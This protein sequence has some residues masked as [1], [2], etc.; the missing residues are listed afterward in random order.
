MREEQVHLYKFHPK[1]LAAMKEANVLQDYLPKAS[2]ENEKNFWL[3]VEDAKKPVNRFITKLIRVKKGKQEYFFYHEEVKSKNIVGTPIH[4][5]HTVGKV[6]VPQYIQE[7]DEKTR[8]LKTTDVEGYQTE[9]ELSWPK[10]FTDELK[11]MVTENCDLTLINTDNKHYGGYTQEQFTSYSFEDLLT[12]GKF[13][14]LTPKILAEIE[15][16]QRAKQT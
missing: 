6:E 13:G 7:Y 8:K 2:E 5:Y 15:K 9:Y 16:K 12:F 11:E 1:V 3:M 14:T 10:D 4:Y